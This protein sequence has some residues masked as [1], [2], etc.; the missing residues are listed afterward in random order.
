M[1]DIKNW[2]SYNIPFYIVRE[3]LKKKKPKDLKSDQK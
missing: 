3:F 1:E 2:D